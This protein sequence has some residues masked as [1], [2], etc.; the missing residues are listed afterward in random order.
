MSKEPTTDFTVRMGVLPDMQWSKGYLHIGF[1]DPREH[2]T[3]SS[4]GMYTILPFCGMVFGRERLYSPYCHDFNEGTVRCVLR[5][6][7]VTFFVDGVDCGVAWTDVTTER[8][9]A[10]VSFWKRGMEVEFL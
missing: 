4:E 10:F 8:M 3:D 5:N 2:S 7:T 6:K 9:H 1:K